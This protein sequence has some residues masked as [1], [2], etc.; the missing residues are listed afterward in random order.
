MVVEKLKK[1]CEVRENYDLVSYNTFK[2]H[3]KCK[4]L[5][6]PITEK[7]LIKVC[8][9]LFKSNEKCLILGNG[10]NI[11]LPKYFDGYIVKYCNNLYTYI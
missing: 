7:E 2:L 6:V 5:I 1:I 11:I 3:S 8:Q 10:S 4:A 9:I